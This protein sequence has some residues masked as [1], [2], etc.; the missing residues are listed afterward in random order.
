M[1]TLYSSTRLLSG[2]TVDDIYIL[3]YLKDPKL[4]EVWC[5]PY[6]GIMGNAG[7]NHQPSGFRDR[8][9]NHPKRQQTLSN[10]KDDLKD[11][12]NPKPYKP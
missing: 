2:V 12:L 10:R 6:Y 4:W 3:H 8:T 1:L 7:F 9:P 5:V 11:T